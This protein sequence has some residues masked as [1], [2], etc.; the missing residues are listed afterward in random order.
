MSRSPD[1][2][3]PTLASPWPARSPVSRTELDPTSFLARSA[4]VHPDRVAVVD[5]ERRCSYAE[6]RELGP[7][8]LDPVATT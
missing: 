6:L 5:G 8:A 7:A 4:A 2:A 3:A 1:A